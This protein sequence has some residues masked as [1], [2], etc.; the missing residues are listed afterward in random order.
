MMPKRKAIKKKIINKAIEGEEE[1][2]GGY[3]TDPIKSTCEK[4]GA[5]V[6]GHYGGQSVYYKCYTCGY[7]GE[8][9]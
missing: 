5:D 6:L 1:L 4:C 7:E 8:I 3:D 2:N 9:Y